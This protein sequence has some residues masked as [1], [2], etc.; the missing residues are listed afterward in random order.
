MPIGYYCVIC[1]QQYSTRSERNEHLET[2]FIHKK[3]D[4]C[5]RL[6]ILIGDLEFELHRPTHCNSANNI[7]DSENLQPFVALERLRDDDI[8]PNEILDEDNDA[9]VE[10]E[11]E[12]SAIL[13]HDTD[14]DDFAL[15]VAGDDS[16]KEEDS[17][18][19]EQPKP[20]KRK[21]VRKK[22]SQKTEDAPAKKPRVITKTRPV[23]MIPCTQ[24]GCTEEFRQQMML[25]KHLKTVHGIVEKHICTICNFPFADKSNLKHHMVSN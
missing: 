8:K 2:H 5:D 21:R 6:V 12:D 14:H 9:G 11:V 19:P 10:V 3:C 7:I 25:R 4:D 24:E 16:T 18:P 13:K 1:S 17:D 15:S 20:I 23:K 22:V